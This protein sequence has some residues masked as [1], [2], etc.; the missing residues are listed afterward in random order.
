MTGRPA[1]T[2]PPPD[3][4]AIRAAKIVTVA[5]VASFFSIV[6][7]TNISDYNTNHEF[8][9]HVLSMD[10]TFGSPDLIWRAID[11]PALHTAAYALIIGWEGATAVTC[12]LGTATLCRAWSAASDVFDRARTIAV[13]GLLLGVILYGFGF[14]VVASE[15]FAMWQSDAWNTQATAGMFTTVLFAA[16][17]FVSLGESSGANRRGDEAA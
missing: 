3:L 6:T 16:L 8:V 9:R 14:L 5:V 11:S 10:T 15:W 1:A 17:I 12:W 2:R 13:I 4:L 7:Y